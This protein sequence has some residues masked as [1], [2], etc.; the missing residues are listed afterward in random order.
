LLVIV[1]V[2]AAVNLLSLFINPRFD[3]T[4]ADLFSLSNGSKRLAAH[5][6]DQL[7]VRAYFSADL[8][9]PHNA[10]E[11]Y[12]RD[13]LSEYETASK[14]KIRVRY[15]HPAT[16][17]EKQEAERDGVV[18]TEDPSIEDDGYSVKEGFRGLAFHYLGETKAIA[19]VDGTAG[20]EYQITQ[21]IKEMVGEKTKIGLLTGHG[22]PTL[23]EG[24]S[25]LKQY[26]P[27]YDIVDVDATQEIAGDLKALLIVQPTTE[28]SDT[29]LRFIDQFVMRG[30]SLGVLGG[31]H[32]VAME[33]QQPPTA[34]PTPS[35]LNP[36]L[37][38]WGVH[39]ENAIVAD[40]QCGRAEMPTR[41]GFRIPVPYPPAPMVSFTEEQSGH[42]VLFNLRQVGLPYPS[43]LTLVDGVDA[44]IK[45]TVIAQS[46]P[47]AWLMTGESIDMAPR[48]SWDTGPRA[49]RT[50]AVAIEG[51]LPSAFAAGPVS[52]PLAAPDSSPIKSP[53]RSAKSVHVLV[54]GTSYFIQDRFLPPPQ[55]SQGMSSSIALALNSI[56]WL[57][58]DS[59][60]IAIRAKTVEDPALEIPSNVKEA[61]ATVREAAQEGDQAKAEAAIDAG[62]AAIAEWKQKKNTYQWAN[63]L[64]IPLAF[65][66]LGLVR[67]RV[68]KARQ[69]SVKL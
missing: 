63:M 21:T 27:T 34:T 1:A 59:D 39:I 15:I 57:A 4:H 18:R 53:E 67:W 41:F 23:T 40:E 65:A 10:T 31:S 19:K 55:Q 46:S 33:E 17:E 7:E 54:I 42:S 9:P 29:E 12:V 14:G 26:L 3:L 49:V 45:R 30:G 6:E 11:R 61:E 16:D 52:S 5:L 62:K 32:K 51:K 44:Q 69:A 2:A 22:G 13:L 68:R 35:G 24:L 20:L 64:G 43:N 56:D 58:Q 60:L 28:L 50:L 38:K 37:E 66:L 48:D 8:P 47:R 36:L 25:A